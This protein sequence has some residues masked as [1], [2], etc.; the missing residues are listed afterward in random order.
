MSQ[1]TCL[2]KKSYSKQLKLKRLINVGC[3]TIVVNIKIT[4]S[5]RTVRFDAVT[6]NSTESA[7]NLWM[8]RRGG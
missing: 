3:N 2:I 5:N 6:H 8:L 4:V 1:N 7:V